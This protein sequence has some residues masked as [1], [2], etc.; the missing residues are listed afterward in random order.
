MKPLQGCERVR[1]WRERLTRAERQAAK[2]AALAADKATVDDN[3]KAGADAQA[4]LVGAM[5]A[6]AD[7]YAAAQTALDGF[8]RA[9]VRV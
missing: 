3:R 9:Q 7:A 6:A 8:G 2:L 5:Q 4:A 1:N